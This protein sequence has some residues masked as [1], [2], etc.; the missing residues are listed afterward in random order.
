LL[1]QVNDIGAAWFPGGPSRDGLECV[2]PL[3]PH[4]RNPTAARNVRAAILHSLQT[5]LLFREWAGGKR[6]DQAAEEIVTLTIPASRARAR[7]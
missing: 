2:L 7:A 4:E 6:V 1:R 5:L 3:T